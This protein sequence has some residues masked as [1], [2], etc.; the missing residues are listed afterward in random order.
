MSWWDCRFLPHDIAGPLTSLI[1]LVEGFPAGGC[2]SGCNH[3]NASLLEAG[4]MTGLERN[5]DIVRMATYAPLFAHVEGWQWRPDL[6]WYDNLSLTRS[7][8]YYVQQMYSTNKG[9]HVLK[10]LDNM[11]K[12]YT[13]AAGQEGQQ[14]DVSVVAARRVVSGR[15]AVVCF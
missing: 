12:P 2:E 9:T 11:Q 15:A 5:A 1:D 8:S 3:F 13:G 7:C 14:T 6:I 4:F 10:L